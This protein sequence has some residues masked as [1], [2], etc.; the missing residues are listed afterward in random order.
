MQVSGTI[1]DFRDLGLHSGQRSQG[2]QV[3]PEKLD[4][5]SR[6][7]AGAHRLVQ[8]RQPA[9]AVPLAEPTDFIYGR[10]EFYSHQNYLTAL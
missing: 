10:T 8:P 6:L 9:H 2:W 4:Q 7:A 1:Q 5:K 3:F